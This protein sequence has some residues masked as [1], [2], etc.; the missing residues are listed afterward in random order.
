M[1][2]DILKIIYLHRDISILENIDKCMEELGVSVSQ[3]EMSNT[4]VEEVNKSRET[5]RA[6][7]KIRREID[8]EF[9]I[10]IGNSKYF[11]TAPNTKTLKEFL[12]RFENGWCV[13][14]VFTC[15]YDSKI[16]NRIR[17]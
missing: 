3:D 4:F 11:L 9:K 17:R 13:N 16:N 14:N 7:E 10:T 12:G 1:N 5:K 15:K 6:I 8:P 2:K